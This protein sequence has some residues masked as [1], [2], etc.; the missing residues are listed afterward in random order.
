M[1]PLMGEN[2]QE[3]GDE[4]SSDS[5]GDLSIALDANG[6]TVFQALDPGTV[7]SQSDVP[8]KVKRPCE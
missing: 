7:F 6:D 2:T 5:T 3:S 8:K 1:P 4:H